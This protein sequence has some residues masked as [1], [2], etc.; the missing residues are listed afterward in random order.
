MTRHPMYPPELEAE[1]F[2]REVTHVR[3][4]LLG[5]GHPFVAAR[6]GCWTGHTARMISFLP[7]RHRFL[8][9]THRNI[10]SLRVAPVRAAS[11]LLGGDVRNS[12]IV[13]FGDGRRFAVAGQ[14]QTRS[15]EVS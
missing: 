3:L 8:M 11:R 10:V 15:G 4:E 5:R 9:T 14:D 6:I 2:R 13:F 7:P 12:P 1:S